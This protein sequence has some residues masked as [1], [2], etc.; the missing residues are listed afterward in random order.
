MAPAHNTFHSPK[1]QTSLAT[2]LGPQG[3]LKDATVPPA[4]QLCLH[5]QQGNGT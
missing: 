2:H 4:P 3:L 1:L 5:F